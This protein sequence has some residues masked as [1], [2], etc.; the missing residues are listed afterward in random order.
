[1]S[2]LLSCCGQFCGYFY[3]VVHDLCCVLVVLC[4]SSEKIPGDVG[5]VHD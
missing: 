3:M 1:M 2:L 4:L 5:H